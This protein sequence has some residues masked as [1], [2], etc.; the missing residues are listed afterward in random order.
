GLINFDGASHTADTNTSFIAISAGGDI[1]IG[2]VDFSGYSNSATIDVSWTDYGAANIIGSSQDDIITGNSDDN[3]I[4]GGDGVD[5][6]DLS[7]GGTDTIVTNAGDSGTTTGNVDEITGF[8]TGDDLLD[9]NL[10][11]GSAQNTV[12]DGSNY[13]SLALFKAAAN[14]ALNSTVKYFI[15]DDGTDTWVAVNRGSG[16]SDLVIKLMGI[17]DATTLS[18]ADIIA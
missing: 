8:T 16:D 7:D 14:D 2:D 1:T 10:V 12:F 17:N 3:V 6:I 9:F 5:T 15:A 18:Y 4:T 13:A 11:A